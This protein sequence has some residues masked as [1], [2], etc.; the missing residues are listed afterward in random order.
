MCS[1]LLNTTTVVQSI[2]KSCMKPNSIGID[3]T[4]GNGYDTAFLAENLLPKGVV[5]A[6]DVQEEAIE[7]TK[8]RLILEG[9]GEELDKRIYLIKDGHENLKHYIEKPVDCIMYNLGYLPK[10]NKNIATSWATT[11]ESLKQGLELLNKGGI[12]SM[13]IYH[14]HSEGMKEKEELELFLSSLRPSKV[15]I[16]RI[17]LPYNN[18]FPPVAYLINKI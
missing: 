4:M 2:I 13:I 17:D 14:G 6:F 16:L 15:R 8:N 7:S 9:Y 18:K 1:R 5:F 3:C 12:I 10:G 11:I